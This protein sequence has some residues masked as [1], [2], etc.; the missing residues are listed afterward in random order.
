[1]NRS[2]GFLALFLG[3]AACAS[4][5]DATQPT[6]EPSVSA[7]VKSAAPPPIESTPPAVSAAPSASAAPTYVP[8][9]APLTM[10]N[11]AK[12]AAGQIAQAGAKMILDS[13]KAW[14]K[15]PEGAMNTALKVTFSVDDKN[16][17]KG[18]HGVGSVYH[19]IAQN[20]PAADA[21][22]VTSAGPKFL[23]RI[24][25]TAKNN[26]ALGAATTDEA[27]KV[28]VTWTVIAPKL[29]DDGGLQFEF[30]EFADLWLQL[31]TDA[32]K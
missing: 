8:T 16:A 25:T 29:T 11:G 10:L 22:K 15:V 27:G 31:T 14:L 4:G 6:A 30:D 2:T 13:T 28:T 26:L 23:V 17:Q 7:P 18:P 24:P 9:G 19:V 12:S 1:M 20:P 3:L 32:P 5:P 21:V